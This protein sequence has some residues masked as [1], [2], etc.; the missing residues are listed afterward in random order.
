MPLV[1]EEEKRVKDIEDDKREG[2][3]L[4][5]SEEVEVEVTSPKPAIIRRPPARR[6]AT[7]PRPTSSRNNQRTSST[8]PPRRT[9]TT[10]KPVSP[11]TE[12]YDYDYYDLPPGSTSEKVRVRVDGTVQCLDRG[13]FPHP[14][15]FRDASSSPSCN[16]RFVSCAEVEGNILGWE[17]ECPRHLTFDPIGGICNW[18]PEGL[19]C[20]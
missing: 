3:I 2:V 17:Y 7:T 4:E 12:S 19:G 8:S 14:L 18:A 16:R 6:P 1:F 15:S 10:R 11:S 5:E 20:D 9:S 13:N